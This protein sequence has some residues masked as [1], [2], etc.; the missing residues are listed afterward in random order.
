MERPALDNTGRQRGSTVKFAK[1]HT[2]VFRC[3]N[4]GAESDYGLQIADG[5]HKGS[6][7]HPAYWCDKC[8]SAAEPRDTWVF[9]A[10]Y[11]PIMALIGAMA[12]DAFPRDLTTPSWMRLLFAALCCIVTGWP[13]S[14]YLSRHLVSWE[15]C[16]QARSCD[17]SEPH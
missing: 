6:A 3:P 11:G 17:S 1:W 13:L 12:F 9:G 4:C 2:V 15:P 7:W 8:H 14:R 10:V 16:S 5:P